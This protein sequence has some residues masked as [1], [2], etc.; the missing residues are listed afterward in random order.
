MDG[1]RIVERALCRVQRSAFDLTAKM[2]SAAR[3]ELGAHELF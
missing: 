2:A 1:A 3:L